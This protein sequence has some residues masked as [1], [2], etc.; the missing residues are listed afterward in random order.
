VS[1]VHYLTLVLGRYTRDSSPSPGSIYKL[2]S[3]GVNDKIYV[4]AAARD[5]KSKHQ[6]HDDVQ[7]V[8]RFLVPLASLFLSWDQVL[9]PTGGV[10]LL[11]SFEM[12]KY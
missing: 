8:V 11:F 7:C 12:S 2:V 1:H 6:P 9:S 5:R 4:I 10:A 3:Y